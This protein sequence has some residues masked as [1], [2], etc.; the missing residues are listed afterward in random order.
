[1]TCFDL[2]PAYIV[3]L[4]TQG[5]SADQMRTLRCDDTDTGV[6]FWGPCAADGAAFACRFYRNRGHSVEVR[7]EYDAYIVDVDSE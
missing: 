4:Q 5:V 1:M 3:W 6:K 2:W 7:Q